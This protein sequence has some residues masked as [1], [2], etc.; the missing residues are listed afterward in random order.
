MALRRAL[1]FLW[2]MHPAR[3]SDLHTALHV[4][5]GAGAPQAA[6]QLELGDDNVLRCQASLRRHPWNDN[7]FSESSRLPPPAPC[8]ARTMAPLRRAATLVLCLLATAGASPTNTTVSQP[9]PSAASFKGHTSGAT[10]LP[11]LVLLVVPG[12]A[13]LQLRVDQA[14]VLLA[15]RREKKHLRKAAGTRD[16]AAGGDTASAAGSESWGGGDAV[17]VAVTEQA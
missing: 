4:T 14:R 16:A 15:R 11:L 5:Q 9:L 3:A 12:A 17:A 1:R 7:I 10:Y 13:V 2:N 6:R 8:A